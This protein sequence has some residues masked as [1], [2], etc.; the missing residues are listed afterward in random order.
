MCENEIIIMSELVEYYG[1]E[2]HFCVKMAPLVEQLEKEENLKVEK[3]EVWHDEK[4]AAELQQVPEFSQCGG[5]PFFLNTKTRKIIC[6]ATDYKSFKAWAK[7][8]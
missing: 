6:G 5:V 4:N 1:T 8:E 3:K 7:G 2:C